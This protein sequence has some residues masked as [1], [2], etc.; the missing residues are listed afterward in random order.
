MANAPQGHNQLA[1]GQKNRPKRR[2]TTQD[3]KLP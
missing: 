1:V 2:K 3:E